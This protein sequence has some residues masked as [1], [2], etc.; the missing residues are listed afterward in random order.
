MIIL[1]SSYHAALYFRF[2]LLYTIYIHI[3]LFSLIYLLLFCL[4][5]IYSLRLLARYWFICA[6]SVIFWCYLEIYAWC[7]V[8]NGRTKDLHMTV[9]IPNMIYHVVHKMSTRHSFIYSRIYAP[10]YASSWKHYTMYLALY[11]RHS[12]YAYL[13]LKYSYL[14]FTDGRKPR[15]CSSCADNHNYTSRLIRFAGYSFKNLLIFAR[16]VHRYVLDLTD[17]KQVWSLSGISA[18]HFKVW[19]RYR[20]RI[21]I[22]H[23]H[24]FECL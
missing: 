14:W 2:H 15:S 7:G 20:C 24:I 18:S 12:R 6:A 10:E 17:C 9:I 5:S 1:L 11:S 4:I 21:I 8:A 16:T 22:I 13:F 19:V 23:S 3:Y